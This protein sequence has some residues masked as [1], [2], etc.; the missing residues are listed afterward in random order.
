MIFLKSLYQNCLFFWN[1]WPSK[2]RQLQ[3][4][5][6]LWN[7]V[8]D[9]I[10]ISNFYIIMDCG[11]CGNFDI[12]LKNFFSFNMVKDCKDGVCFQKQRIS[13][14]SD[15]CKLMGIFCLFVEIEFTNTLL[16]PIYYF[17][18]LELRQY[19]KD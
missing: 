4:Y 7:H 13:C 18:N 15:Y 6:V 11:Y 8:I 14:L 5:V 10:C 12:F 16:Y 2:I 19:K 1:G 9:A 3:S 17:D